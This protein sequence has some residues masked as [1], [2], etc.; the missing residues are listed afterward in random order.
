M[1]TP[2]ALSQGQI[3]SLDGLRA[4]SILV[5]FISHLGLETRIPGGFGVTVF[6]F[7]SGYLI[8]SLLVREHARYGAVSLKRFYLRRLLRLT[9]PLLLTLLGAGALVLLGI[10][11]GS[12]DPATLL[13]QIFFF[14]NYFALYGPVQP[15]EGLGI[16]WSL[17]VEEHFYLIWPALFLLVMRGRIGLWHLVALM[18]AILIWRYVRVLGFGDEEWTI[19]ISTDTRFDS[20]LFGCLLALL[21]DR[22]PGQD[23]IWHKPLVIYGLLGLALAVILFTFVYRDPVFRS[24]WRYSLQG[25]ALMPIFYYAVTHPRALVFQPLN[26]GFVRRIGIWSYTMYLCHYVIIKALEANGIAEGNM[27]AFAALAFVLSCLWSELVFRVGEKPLHPWR[28]KL[29][30]PPPA[31]DGARSQNS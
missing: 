24:T 6:F 16:L 5:V 21:Q 3:P 15:I 29:A 26:W 14:Y 13:S 22:L 28:K 12:L 11:N 18:G 2:V 27:L 8:T 19:Y 30:G 25:I 7:L 23:T 20:L 4:V 9:P 31:P 1:T 10:A 17:S